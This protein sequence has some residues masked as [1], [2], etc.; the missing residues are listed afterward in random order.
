MDN[1]NSSTVSTTKKAHAKGKGKGKSALSPAGAATQLRP[2]VNG[3]RKNKATGTDPEAA[4]IQGMRGQGKSPLKVP[5]ERKALFSSAMGSVSNPD[6]RG[7]RVSQAS[8]QRVC[9]SACRSRLILRPRLTLTAT[10]ISSEIVTFEDT[11]AS[12]END[13]GALLFDSL[14]ASI[15]EPDDP[16]T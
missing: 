7:D 2:P 13:N 15:S 11:V 12:N 14:S 10:E 3:A 6:R 5:L 16:A 8:F 9:S 4:D 1:G